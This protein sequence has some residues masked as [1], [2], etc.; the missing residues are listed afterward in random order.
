MRVAVV[1]IGETLYYVSVGERVGTRYEVITV[2]ADS[3]D[4]K[5]LTDGFDPPACGCGLTMARLKAAPYVEQGWERRRA[6]AGGT[7][8]RLK[9]GAPY[10]KSV[11]SP[12]PLAGRGLG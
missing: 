11:R 4:L 2:S 10:A 6:A 3:I 7:M 1:S 8:A 12:L 9:A 5:D